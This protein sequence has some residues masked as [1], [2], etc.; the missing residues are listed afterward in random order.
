MENRLIM[1]PTKYEFEVAVT[2]FDI[3]MEDMGNYTFRAESDFGLQELTFTLN[4][5]GSPKVMISSCSEGTD[6]CLNCFALGY[7]KPK[8]EWIAPLI[9]QNCPDYD[10][11]RVT[12]MVII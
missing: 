1:S 4:V 7:P 12:L 6:V 11:Y 3:Q 10:C 9:S 2:I 8:V 5:V